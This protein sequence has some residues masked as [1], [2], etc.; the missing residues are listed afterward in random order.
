MPKVFKPCKNC[1]V[2]MEIDQHDVPMTS[3]SLM[4]VKNVRMAVIGL[5]C[6]VFFGIGGCVTHRWIEGRE[7][8]LIIKD[9]SVKIDMQELPNTQQMRKFTRP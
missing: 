4:W 9:P 6:L 5:I 1:G 8:E 2:M 7:M 3:D